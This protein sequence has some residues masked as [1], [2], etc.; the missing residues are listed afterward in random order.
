MSHT[1]KNY[2]ADIAYPRRYAA[3]TRGFWPGAGPYWQDNRG[4]VLH[5]LLP[6]QHHRGGR[7]H[8]VAVRL[9]VGHVRAA[10]RQ[11][12]L[13][14]VA[15]RGGDPGARLLRVG[16]ARAWELLGLRGG[17]LLDMLAVRGRRAALARHDHDESAPG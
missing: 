15:V 14:G 9:A 13:G 4:V 12:C 5:R 2:H 11:R 10:D 16:L 1:A 3:G 6:R 7:P 8:R 17:G